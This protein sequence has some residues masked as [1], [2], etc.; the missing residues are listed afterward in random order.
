MSGSQVGAGEME[1]WMEPVAEGFPETF[2]V[3]EIT[4]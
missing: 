3:G 4:R 1:V 2:G